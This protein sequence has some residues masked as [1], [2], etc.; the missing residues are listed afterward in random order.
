MAS[1]ATEVKNELARV[2]GD[3]DCCRIAELAEHCL[4]SGIKKPLLVTDKALASLP[5][6]R[7]AG[8][9]TWSEAPLAT[10]RCER[11]G[12]GAK[13]RYTTAAA[14]SISGKVGRCSAEDIDHSQFNSCLR[15][16]SKRSE[17]I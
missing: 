4:A 8:E 17:P 15:M 12:V 10:F 1:Y 11:A 7:L 13:A 2:Q 5:T 6:M 3:N 9:A 14:A 16:T